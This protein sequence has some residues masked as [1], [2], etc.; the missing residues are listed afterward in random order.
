MGSVTTTTRSQKSCVAATPR[1]FGAG[2]VAHAPAARRT[3]N[4]LQV[5]AERAPDN[6]GARVRLRGRDRRGCAFA[7]RRRLR[8]GRR[9]A[10]L[11]PA[12][13]LA[14]ACARW[15]SRRASAAAPARRRRR[16]RRPK[17]RDAGRRRC[18]QRSPP[19]LRSAAPE[20][21]PLAEIGRAACR[22]SRRVL[23][24][25]VL[26]LFD[27][28]ACGRRGWRSGPA[29]SASR[30]TA[31][32]RAPPPRPRGSGNGHVPVVVADVLGEQQA[33][34]SVVFLTSATQRACRE[35]THGTACARAPRRRRAARPPAQRS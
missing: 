14:A 20:A 7:P 27:D 19:P 11:V 26:H 3:A 21:A 5:A 17:L 34:C 32:C 30:R 15:P 18:A 25:V 29:R 6:P 10:A 28:A 9:R 2:K 1:W 23:G 16:R 4:E 31:P 13:R 24:R 35:G 12:P 8:P 33:F 22:W